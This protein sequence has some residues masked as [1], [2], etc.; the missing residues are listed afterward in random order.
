MKTTLKILL[1]SL[2]YL[3]LQTLVSAILPF[4][5]SFK[6]LSDVQ[7]P[8]LSMLFL[9]MTSLWNAIFIYLIARYTSYNKTKTWLLSSSY[10]F[11]LQAF[12]TQIETLFFIGSF[13]ALKT[14]DVILI[15]AGPFPAILVSVWAGLRL[16]KHDPLPAFE[17][18]YISHFLPKLILI[19]ILYLIVYMS[20]GYFVAWQF[21]AVRLHYSGSLEKETFFQV[22]AGNA[23]ETPWIYPFQIMR[24]LLFG[25]INYLLYLMLVARRKVYVFASVF[26]NIS[27]GLMLLV[28]NPLFTSGA[29]MGHFIEMISSMILFSF[30]MCRIFLWKK[31]TP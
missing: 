11:L 19:G 9:W 25:G 14:T 23:R 27:L 4:S 10:L 20:F 6:E 26:S 24:G 17:R 12:M 15:T 18:P 21:D 28:P 16:F 7:D 13:A 8:S 3:V 22:L 30:L 2:I 1:V 5:E 31:D 29:R